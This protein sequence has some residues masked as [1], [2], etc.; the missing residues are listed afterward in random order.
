MD[1]GIDTFPVLADVCESAYCSTSNGSPA[2][3]A[4]RKAVDPALYNRGP[5]PPESYRFGHD[6]GRAQT[7][8]V[9]LSARVCSS[10]RTF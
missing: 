8:M 4:S 6:R 3:N 5:L 9:T 10:P 1:V 2:G 7:S